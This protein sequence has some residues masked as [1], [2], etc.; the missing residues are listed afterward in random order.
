MIGEWMNAVGFLA[1]SKTVFLY[2]TF[3][4]TVSHGNLG[5]RNQCQKDAVL[6]FHEFS[7]SSRLISKL[8]SLSYL[9]T[10]T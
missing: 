6:I 3:P 8:I 4:Y 2:L 1:A 10:E 5:K 7:L 9:L